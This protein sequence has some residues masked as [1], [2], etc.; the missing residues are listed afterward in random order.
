MKTLVGI[1][2]GQHGVKVSITVFKN[3]KMVSEHILE[4]GM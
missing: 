2:F 1:A 4:L 3:R